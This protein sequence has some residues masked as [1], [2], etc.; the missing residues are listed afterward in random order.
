MTLRFGGRSRFHCNLAAILS[1]G[2]VVG[3]LVI[4]G[5]DHRPPA[6]D[7]N[8]TSGANASSQPLADSPVAAEKRKSAF[9]PP[10]ASVD[11]EFVIMAYNVENL[12]DIDG[13]A[14]FEDYLP[15]QYGPA[16]LLKKVQAVTR[17]LREFQAGR[18]PEIVLFQELE[19]DRSPAA[20]PLDYQRLLEPYQQLSVEEMLSGEVSPD[21]QDL[22]VEALLLK[23]F[24]DQGLGPYN[25]AVAEFRE[26]PT[27]RT[28]AH[29]NATFSRFPIADF[30]THQ[31]AGARGT[32]E[33]IHQV[34]EHTL[35][36]LNS[37]WKSGASNQ[38]SERIRN[39]NAQAVRDRLTEILNDDPYADVVLGGDYNSHYN[40]S[41]RFPD[42]KPTAVNDTLG[43]QGDEMAIRE[44]AGPD[45]YNLWYELPPLQRG[46]DTYRGQWGTLMQ[47]MITRGLYDFRGVQYVDNS[48]QVAAFP[49]VN[50]Q[51][52]SGM[53]LRWNWVNNAGT[54]FSDHLPI[55]AR[56]RLVETGDSDRLVELSQP[57]RP[58]ETA[59][60]LNGTTVNFSGISA[61]SVPSTETLGSDEMIQ[62]VDNVGQV[63][64]VKAI[65]S[66]ERPFVIKVFEDEYKVWSFDQDL[67]LKI[68]DKFPLGAEMKFLGEFGQHEGAWQFI[69]RDLSWLEPV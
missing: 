13:Q 63:F 19:Y 44:I 31:S 52:G 1:A 62:D 55:Y 29:V 2:L 59:A 58:S 64:L 12:F 10:A 27:G 50:A 14:V 9:A 54:G 48:K 35:H 18:G 16:H 23:A 17:I 47:M 32:L 21:I 42:F 30:R 11:G 28:V 41:Q 43:S 40:Q 3:V 7:E 15:P 53:P 45:L 34:G 51:V 4:G 33:V 49:G 24:Q 60:E 36:T 38:E 6:S 69:V 20:R 26:D 39:K 46:S 37:H 61:A 57:G 56:F 8:E 65:V 68:Y 66:G 67:R 5:C 22:P 25:V